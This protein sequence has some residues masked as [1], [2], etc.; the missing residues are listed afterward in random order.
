VHVHGH[1]EELLERR[2]RLEQEDD[3][4]ATLDRFHRASQQVWRERLEVLQHAH[5]VGAAQDF[6]SFLIVAVPGKIFN[7]Y[8]TYIT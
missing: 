8:I 5:A 1:G 2:N 4:S 6:V 3:D 7:V